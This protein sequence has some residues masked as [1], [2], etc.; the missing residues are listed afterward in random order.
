MNP[1]IISTL[2]QASE[3]LQ[4]SDFEGATKL[5]LKALQIDP[6]NSPA[7][8]MLG[9]INATK[10]DLKEAIKLLKK[11]AKISPND[12]GLIYNLGKVLSDA[13]NE[14][15][16]LPYHQKSTTLVPSNPNAWLNFSKS[17]AAS[18]NFSLALDAIDKALKLGEMNAE[19]WNNKGAILKELTRYSD[20]LEAYKKA[21]ELK[22]D[23]A[24]ALYNQGI[25]FAAMEDH[26]S[27][28]GFFDRAIIINPDYFAARN[29][30]GVSLSKLMRHEE[31]LE[32]YNQS[33]R[34][35]P[36]YV[37]ALINKAATLTYLKRFD[38]AANIL[39]K[40]IESQPSNVS[41]L[42]NQGLIFYQVKK[43]DA[44]LTYF[45]R[46]TKLSPENAEAWCNMG[47]ALNDL[48][49]F[50]KAIPAY[51][52]ALKLNPDR[53]FLR[54]NYL[55]AKM[56]ICDWSNFSNS[57]NEINEQI[58]KGQKAIM[59][60][61]Y[62]AL[63]ESEELHRKATEIWVQSKHPPRNELPPMPQR[64]AKNK[65]RL[66]YFSAD[67]R[68]HPVA[69]L[70]VELFETHNKNNFE[71]FGFSFGVD[72]QSEMRKRIVNA[73][74]KFIDV[75]KLSD[76]EVAMMARDFEID[77]AIDLTGLTADAR[78]DVFAHRAAPVQI[79]F[80]GYPGTLG[81]EYIDYII[82]DRILIPKEAQQHYAEKVLYLPN[83]YQPND[84]KRKIS[85][86]AFTRA[87]AGLPESGFI[88]CS[89]NNNF[90]ITPDTFSGW[91]RILK[92][93][94]DSALWLL[95]DNPLAAANLSKEAAKYGV[96]PN[97]LIF[98]RRLPLPDHLARH[99]LADLFLDTSP[100]GA[101]TTTS[102]ALWAGLPV[103]TK[104][105]QSF[106]G[107]VAASLLTAVDLPEL[108]TQSQDEYE[109]LAIELATN[110][111][112][113]AHIK[114]KL[115]NNR[116]NSNLFNVGQFTQQIENLYSSVM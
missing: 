41:A 109:A 17:L 91:M 61:P 85:G 1:L 22:P 2:T 47:I 88:F 84:T 34:I 27:A 55:G 78:L 69:N 38:E 16:A 114:T 79:N 89:F 80:L 54:G 62:L 20:A 57:L 113:L 33:L 23:F 76:K 66:G 59:P 15:E 49:Q 35:Q 63:T 81:A 77:I 106:A 116:N 30:K 82:A 6:N 110:P 107:R 92:A 51:E 111:L 19:A 105:G 93:V 32:C 12:P 21:L 24:E 67:F 56:H 97:R 98:A 42:L 53:E 90:K 8:Q 5:L 73:F 36:N 115:V 112:K 31:A 18:K 37:E 44:A 39:G 26:Q 75:Q 71:I 45:Q 28:L 46:A 95:E 25:T 9:L 68:N 94:E 52:I 87:D 3:K 64:S 14:V 11:A 74:D 10:G 83:S 102:D 72:D 7:L 70:I 43:I 104:I 40:V 58:E 13:G 103:L 4:Q 50:E 96:N 48:K 60:F 108:I 65:I 100:Y 99:K 101:H 29:N 86:K